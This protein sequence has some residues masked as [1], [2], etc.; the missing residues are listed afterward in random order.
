M[1]R[2]LLLSLLLCLLAP[3]AATAQLEAPPE[4]VTPSAT[5]GMASSDSAS[6]PALTEAP[7]TTQRGGAIGV[8]VGIGDQNVAM[9]DNPLFQALGVKKVRYFIKWDAIDR[10]GELAI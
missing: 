1:S 5:G 10:P 3:G 8:A 7:A 9:F 6:P 2:T 4:D